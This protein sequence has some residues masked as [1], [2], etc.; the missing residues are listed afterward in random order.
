MNALTTQTTGTAVA[1]PVDYFDGFADYGAAVAG[2]R[3]VGTLLKFSKGDYLVGQNGD[4]MEEGTQL[5]A[6]MAEVVTGWIKW[7]D[8]KPAEQ[9][10]GKLIDTFGK[11]P[12]FKVPT[13]KE[14]GDLDETQWPTD[15]KG[16]PQ[17]PWQLTNYVIFKVPGLDDQEALYT[18]PINSKGAH[19]A[20]GKLS[21]SY[22]KL[23]RMRQPGEMP[24]VKLGVERYQH[25]VYGWIKNP[26]FKIV[27]WVPA[28]EFDKAL[29]QEAAQAQADAEA[30]KAADEDIPF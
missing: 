21:T 2:T 25:K 9:I 27:G 11:E 28:G 30:R 14:L 19:G 1:A 3:I 13:R 16:N 8:K 26:D 24:I 20:F 5:A 22:S 4:I 17:D 18:M 15:D 6:N 29:A 7:E 23:G 12:K 10:M